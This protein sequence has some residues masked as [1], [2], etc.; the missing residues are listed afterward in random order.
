MKMKPVSSS[1]LNS[2]GY[3]SSSKKLRIEF[4]SGGLYE[5]SGVPSSTYD[6]LMSASSKGS[7][8]HNNIKDRYPTSKLR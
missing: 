4:H 3:E 6:S 1:N 5:Y 8:F 7:Y 2:V